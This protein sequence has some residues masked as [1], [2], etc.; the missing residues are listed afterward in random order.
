MFQMSELVTTV[1][2]LLCSPFFLPRWLTKIWQMS[3]ADTI[4]NMSANNRAAQPLVHCSWYILVYIIYTND[5]VWVIIRSL[6]LKSVVLGNNL[7]KILDNTVLIHAI[8]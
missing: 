7:E 8:L 2:Y 4:S 3:L 1:A 5:Q 6:Y